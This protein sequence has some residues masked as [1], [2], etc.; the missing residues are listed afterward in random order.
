[1]KFISIMSM[2]HLLTMERL[3]DAI[4]VFYD[5]EESDK[6]LLRVNLNFFK[7]R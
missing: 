4:M 1:M 2:Q 6:N 3:V 7:G 5:V